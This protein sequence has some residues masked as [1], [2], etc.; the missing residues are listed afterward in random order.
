MKGCIDFFSSVSYLFIM[1][2]IW[3]FE[4]AVFRMA[5]NCVMLS[6]FVKEVVHVVY[7]II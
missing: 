7:S 3:S 1:V 5:L 2:T 4:E 6:E